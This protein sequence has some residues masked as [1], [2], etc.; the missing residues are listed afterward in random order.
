MKTA[1]DL[2]FG[3]R[4]IIHSIDQLHPS[5]RRIIEYGFTPGQVIILAHQTLFS[6][7]LAFIIRGTTIAIRR[8]EAKSILVE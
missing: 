3:E 6:D 2:R 8:S 1:A 7:P 4:G 5:A